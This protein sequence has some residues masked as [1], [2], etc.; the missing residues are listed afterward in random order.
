[1]DR[2]DQTPDRPDLGEASEQLLNN[3]DNLRDA[4]LKRTGEIQETVGGFVR[5]RPLTSLAIG[6]GVG[7][8]LSGALYSR[9]TGRLLGLGSRFLLGALAKQMLAGGG[10]GAL[11]SLI[12]ERTD[13]IQH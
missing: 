8:L 6:F 10:L 3:L 4:V 11:A 9:T 7:Y 5:E 12:P 2:N 13:D 1:M